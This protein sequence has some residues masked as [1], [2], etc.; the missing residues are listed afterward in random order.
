MKPNSR[1]QHLKNALEEI[2]RGNLDRALADLRDIG[3]EAGMVAEAL[4][5]RENRDATARN[6]ATP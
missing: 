5:Y 4:L 3:G 6:T 2:R 1:T